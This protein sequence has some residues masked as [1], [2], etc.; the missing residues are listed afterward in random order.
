MEPRMKSLDVLRSKYNIHRVGIMTREGLFVES[1]Y[2]DRRGEGTEKGSSLI[3]C[4]EG[5]ASFC[6]LGNCAIPLEEGY[7]TLSWNHPGFG[8]SMGMPFPEQEKNAV[9]AVVLFALHYLHFE[10]EDIRFFGW[11][12]GGFSA[13]WAAMHLPRAGGLILDAT[14]DTIDEL[15]KRAVPIFGETLPLLMVRR[16]FDLNNAE[17]ITRYPGPVRII[18]R[19]EDEVISTNPDAPCCSNRGNFLAFRLLKYRFPHLFNAD[20]EEVLWSFL[21]MSKTEQQS[22]R[23]RNGIVDEAMLPILQREFRKEMLNFAC[24]EEQNGGGLSMNMPRSLPF[25]SRLGEKDVSDALKRSLLIYLAS[26]YFEEAKGSHCSPLERTCFKEP[27]SESLVLSQTVNLNLVQE[28]DE[29]DA[30]GEHDGNTEEEEG[31]GWE[32]VA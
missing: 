29:G 21:A 11:S 28:E 3:I 16:Y 23:E 6:E 7:S 5:N 2:A 4:C 25:P 9:E 27:W 31:N 24:S 20:T 32:K 8:S 18:R 30:S 19:S 26:K 1:F 13:T 14:F 10:P 12:I 15:S 17:F 22:F